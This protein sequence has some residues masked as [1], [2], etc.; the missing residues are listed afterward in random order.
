[1]PSGVPVATVAW[2]G[3]SVSA[4]ILAAQILS[5]SRPDLVAV[6]RRHKQKLAAK[7]ELADRRIQGGLE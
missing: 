1:M 4:A 7:V 3:R 6:L 5:L 2:G